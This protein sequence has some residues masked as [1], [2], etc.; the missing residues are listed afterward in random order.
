M[1]LEGRRSWPWRSEPKGGGR[2]RNPDCDSIL[3][4]MRNEMITSGLH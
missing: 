1:E 2:D 3:I 4:S